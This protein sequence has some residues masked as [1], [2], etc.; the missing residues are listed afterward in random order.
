MKK[1]KPCGSNFHPIYSINSRYSIKVQELTD[2]LTIPIILRS[3]PIFRS[4]QAS[5]VRSLPLHREFQCQ[6]PIWTRPLRPCRDSQSEY[7]FVFLLRTST[8][9]KQAWMALGLASVRFLQRNS[10]WLSMRT[11]RSNWEIKYLSFNSKLPEGL[12]SSQGMEDYRKVPGRW[13]L[14]CW[15]GSILMMTYSPGDILIMASIH[16]F[17]KQKV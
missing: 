5:R 4:A 3:F 10:A 12:S 17:R 6:I 11:V 14:L 16:S 1:L 9:T 8:I 2:L 7:N 15:Q 13:L